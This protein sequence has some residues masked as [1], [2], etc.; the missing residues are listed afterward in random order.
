MLKPMRLS[1]FLAPLLALVM[2]S[3]ATAQPMD[4]SARVETGIVPARER[5]APGG[6][7]P[8]AVV[9]DHQENWHIHTHDPQVPPELG[10]PSFYIATAIE[11]EAGD[12]VALQPRIE[13]IQWPEAKVIEVAFVGEP[14]DYAVY[15]GRAVA[16]LPVTVAADAPPGEVS[17][18]VRLTYQACDDSSCLRPVRGEVHTVTLEVVSPDALAGTETSPTDAELFAGFDAD[19]ETHESANAPDAPDAAGE[20][21]A[22]RVASPAPMTLATLLSILLLAFAGG[23]VLNVM[24]CVLPVIPIKI[25][26]LVQAAPQRGRRLS[27]GLMMSLGV[28]AFWVVLGLILAVLAEGAISTMFG[29]WQFNLALGLLIVALAM[30]MWNMFAMQLPQWVY[31]INP[32]HDS[33]SGAFGFGVMTAVLA[34]PCTGPFLG[35]AAGTAVGT[36]ALIAFL[37]FAAIG[38]GMAIPY[39]VLTAWPKLVDRLPRTGPASELVKQ[40]LGLLMIAAGAFFIGVAVNILLSDGTSGVYQWYWWLT[41][42]IVTAAG[43]WLIWRTFRITPSAG[44]RIAFGAVGL[45][46]AGGSLT[47]AYDATRPSGIDWVYYTPDRLE[48]VRDAGDVVVLDFTAD[49]CINCKVLERTVLETDAVIAALAPRNVT[50]MKVDLTSSSAPGWS[51]LAAHDRVAI[52]L[53]VVLAPDGQTVFKEEIYTPGQ[54]VAAIERAQA[55][56]RRTQLTSR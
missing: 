29:Y 49:W 7:V 19:W 26:G 54:V 8:V 13:H 3:P 37:T 36:S 24:P 43:L 18:E 12:A 22:Q 51:L 20:V 50:A 44:R 46:L 38:A 34:T 2:L 33:Y 23:M 5:V 45:L 16:Y 52:P 11:A 15:A 4:S 6:M 39:F 31:R 14:V 35:A 9:F 56:T 41:A 55:D 40:F 32:R 17:L 42:G 25:L 28:L 30:S 47:F 10:D 53:L 48:A 1:A 21:E 27:L